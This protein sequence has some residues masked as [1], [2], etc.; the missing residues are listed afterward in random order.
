VRAKSPSSY[1]IVRDY[2]DGRLR[3]LVRRGAVQCGAVAVLC[4]VAAAAGWS[5]VGNQR[6]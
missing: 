1:V 3:G 5:K 4:G 2:G 6:E